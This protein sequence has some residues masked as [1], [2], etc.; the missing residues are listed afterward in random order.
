MFLIETVMDTL[1]EIFQQLAEVYALCT[2]MSQGTPLWSRL[3]FSTP[4]LTFGPDIHV[5]QMKNPSDFG[6]PPDFSTDATIGI[7]GELLDGFP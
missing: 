5:P 1:S 4:H 3:K 7:P 6:G 2:T